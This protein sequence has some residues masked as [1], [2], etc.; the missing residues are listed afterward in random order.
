[1]PTYYEK[2]DAW[3]IPKD[4]AHFETLT[5]SLVGT[6]KRFQ[7]FAEKEAERFCRSVR[8]TL[9]DSTR[10]KPEMAKPDVCRKFKLAARVANMAR[11]VAMAMASSAKECLQL[12]KSELDDKI[13]EAKKELA[14]LEDDLAGKA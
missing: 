11:N 8:K 4:D 10:G 3:L 6:R 1:M 13:K 7:A 12:N 9:S 5:A 14:K 2:Q